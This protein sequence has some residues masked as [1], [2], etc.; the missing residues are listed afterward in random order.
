M[1]AKKPAEVP[2][3][4][5]TELAA[6]VERDPKQVRA[7]LRKEF[8]RDPEA[9]GSSWKITAQ[10]QEQTVNHFTALNERKEA[11]AS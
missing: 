11:K 7:Y 1:A 3:I 9:K 4:T 2:T 5:A 10:L 6:L 8:A